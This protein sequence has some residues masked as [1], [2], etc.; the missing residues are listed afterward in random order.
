MIRNCNRIHLTFS[1]FPRS[2]H[3]M[4]L[5]IDMK[6]ILD[7]GENLQCCESWEDSPLEFRR[8]TIDP[9]QIFEIP[10]FQIPFNF[11]FPGFDWLVTHISQTEHQVGEDVGLVVDLHVG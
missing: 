9:N 5:Y 1:V 8:L 10:S 6:M 3:T 7:L 11:V 2:P 4:S